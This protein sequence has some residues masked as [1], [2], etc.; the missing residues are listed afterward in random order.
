MPIGTTIGMAIAMQ[1][2]PSNANSISATAASSSAA[3]RHADRQ[4]I[5]PARPKIEQI[6]GRNAR[7]K[8]RAEEQGH[9]IVVKY[10]NRHLR[11]YRRIKC[12]DRDSADR[13]LHRRRH[14]GLPIG[15]AR[16]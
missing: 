9:S 5:R 6:S 4:P 8:R 11:Q 15:L 10:V 13:R 3:A 12:T 1:M 7:D 16:C 2:T 14:I